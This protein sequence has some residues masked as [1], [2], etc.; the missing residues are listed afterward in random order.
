MKTLLSLLSAILCLAAASRV[1]AQTFKLDKPVYEATQSITATWTGGPGNGTDWIGIY[2]EGQTPGPTPSTIWFYVN[3]TRDATTGLTD[4]SVTFANI[5]LT[6]GNWVAQFLANDG[7][8]AIAEPV[9][10]TVEGVIFSSFSADVG[11]ISA[12]VPVNLTWVID[13]NGQPIPTATLTGGPAPVDVTGTDTIQVNPTATT[14]YT[15]TVTGAAPRTVTVYLPVA[16]S[17]AFSLDK[18]G[19][20]ADKA[21]TAS[22]S[23]SPGN[24]KDW[25]GIYKMTDR[26]GPVPATRWWYA[27]GTRTST[28]GQTSGSVGFA[29]ALAPGSY[30]AALFLNDGYTLSAGPVAFV[31]RPG[32]FEITDFQIL[33][34]GEI[35]M[36]W[37]SDPAAPVLYNVQESSDLK[38]WTNVEAASGLAPEP[39]SA[40]TSVTFTPAQAIEGSRFYKVAASP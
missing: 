7:Y 5:T 11:V 36:E 27:N 10:F 16:N 30:F 12:G 14:T 25:I 6:P 39:D 17:A 1:S 29:P 32:P 35:S 18:T 3:G 28:E 20:T 19:F 4:G 21:L 34:T 37:Y 8:E 23:G 13:P 38:T 22:W 15:L 33:E 26:P 24:P 2:K 9:P 31:V 40:T